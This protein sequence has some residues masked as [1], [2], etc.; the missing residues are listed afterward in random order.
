MAHMAGVKL[1]FNQE[2]KMPHIWH[3]DTALRVD[4]SFHEIEFDSYR[5]ETKLDIIRRELELD[6]SYFRD[7]ST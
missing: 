2:L 3:M 7:A 6:R 4:Q 1:C 5:C